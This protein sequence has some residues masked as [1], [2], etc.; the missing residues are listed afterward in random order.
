MTNLS[1]KEREEAHITAFYKS[2]LDLGLDSES[3]KRKTATRFSITWADVDK[4][5]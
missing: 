4:I 5:I 1:L 2:L 3:A